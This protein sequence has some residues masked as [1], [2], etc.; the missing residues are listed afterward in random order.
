M[1]V[2]VYLPPYLVG[3]KMSDWILAKAIHR[4]HMLTTKNAMQQEGNREATHIA[5]G[6]KSERKKSTP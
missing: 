1:R 2:T 4:L 3:L 5:Q 6:S